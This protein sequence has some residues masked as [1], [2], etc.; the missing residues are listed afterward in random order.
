MPRPSN[1]SKTQLIWRRHSSIR[2]FDDWEQLDEEAIE[3]IKKVDV[4]SI[5]KYLNDCL[6]SIEETEKQL[7]I[8]EEQN[9]IT[10]PEAIQRSVEFAEGYSKFLKEQKEFLDTFKIHDRISSEEDFEAYEEEVRAKL[11]QNG[12][13]LDK[14]YYMME[15]GREEIDR[16]CIEHE[17]LL[18]EVSQL[19]IRDPERFDEEVTA[20][21]RLKKPELFNKVYPVIEHT[22]DDDEDGLNQDEEQNANLAALGDQDTI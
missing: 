10:D 17:V 14:W 18:K 20:E 3:L 21:L 12:D 4:D 5:E 22:S 8:E 11:L 6:T 2:D 15:E 19:P 13:M 9:K 16:M 7:K 1:Q